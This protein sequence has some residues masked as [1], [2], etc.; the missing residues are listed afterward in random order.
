MR[1]TSILIAKIDFLIAMITHQ[2]TKQELVKLINKYQIQKRKTLNL[3]RAWEKTDEKFGPKFGSASP[4]N[5]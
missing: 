3:K 4:K 2:D 5:E 1:T